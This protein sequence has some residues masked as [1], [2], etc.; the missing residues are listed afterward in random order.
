MSN[1]LSKQGGTLK[2]ILQS[3]GA[4][5]QFQAVLPAHCTPERFTRVAITALTR[6]PKLQNCSKESFFKCLMDLSAVGLEPDGRRAHLIPYGKECTLVLDYKGI[7][8]LMR[9]SGDVV[10][11][12][13]DVVCENDT[14][15][16]SKG[17]ILAHSF[18]LKG[19]RGEMYAAYTEVTFKDG[20]TQSAIMSKEEIESIRARSKAGKSGP[21]VTDYNEMAKKTTL[22][23]VSKL[24]TLSPEVQD[25]FEADQRREFEGLRNVTQK[26][27]VRQN[28]INPFES[29]EAEPS[30]EDLRNDGAIEMEE[31]I[32]EEAFN[33]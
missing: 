11:I 16:H 20:S 33:D 13:S 9:R 17:E 30:A 18:D 29:L 25:V 21:W 28:P 19:G 6:T 24:V 26:P 5:E 23:R 27:Q 4:K 3:D 10:R 7:V 8:E 12:H 14:F 15:E 31:A 22:R 1:T 32:G 2:S